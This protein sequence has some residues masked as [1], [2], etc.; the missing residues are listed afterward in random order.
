IGADGSSRTYTN[1]QDERRALL[2]FYLREDIEAI[3]DAFTALLPAGKAKFDPATFL[4]MD[5]KATAETLAIE[6]QWLTI[7]ELREIAGRAPLPDGA[8]KVLAR[9]SPRQP[10]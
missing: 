6:G 7:D 9:T 2:D 8:G 1:M 5:T 10:D 4:R 3:E